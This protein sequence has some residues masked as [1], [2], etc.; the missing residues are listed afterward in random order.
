MV[1]LTRGLKHSEACSIPAD[2]CCTGKYTIFLPSNG[3]KFSF[4]ILKTI[5]FYLRVLSGGLL[6]ILVVD[7]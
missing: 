1:R 7:N 5:T 4:L 6:W 2:L 3:G